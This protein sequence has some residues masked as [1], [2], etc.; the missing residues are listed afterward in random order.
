MITREIKTAFS[1]EVPIVDNE[2]SN[3]IS[4]PKGQP[5]KY[6]EGDII[7]CAIFYKKTIT[8]F[9]REK[10]D[11]LNKF[12]K[13][14]INFLDKL[15]DMWAFNVFME[16]GNFNG[17]LGKDYV[18]NEIKPFKGKG[19]NK[20]K[21]FNELIDDEIVDKSLVPKD[22]LND[23]HE[24]LKLYSQNEYKSI[25]E[26][27]ISDVIKQYFIWANKRYFWEKYNEYLN[28]DGWYVNEGYK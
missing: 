24:V 2:I 28:E 17:F 15:P 11:D 4:A 12:K 19:W 23:S 5:W 6:E 1:S 21:F 26:H 7:S 3:D 8:V 25:I 27:N 18:I 9:L 14:L 16:K 20:D 22:P 10:D 13:T